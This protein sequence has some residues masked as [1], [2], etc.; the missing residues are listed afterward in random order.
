MTSQPDSS[1]PDA[2]T[3]ESSTPETSPP[4]PTDTSDPDASGPGAAPEH[5]ERSRPMRRPLSFVRRSNRLKPSYQRTWDAALGQEL[6]DIPHGERDTSVAEDFSIDWPAEFGRTA[7]IIVEIGSGSGEA[8]AQAAANHP[9]TDFLAIEVYRPGAAQL[10]SRVRREGLRNVRV[11]VAN[12]PEV[13]DQLFA[14]GQVSEVWIF[15]PDPWHKKKHNKRRLIDAG[16]LTKVARVLPE[17]GVFR[18]ATDWS[19]YAV[20]MRE[21]LSASEQFSN[22][23]AGERSGEESP[24]TEVRLYDLD[25][26]S[27]GRDPAPLPLEQARDDDGGWAPRFS[28]R[29]QTDF[30]SKALAVGRRIFDLTYIRRQDT[31]D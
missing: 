31:P 11:A 9:E 17:G 27:M 19:G 30:E 23:H 6:L 1:Q 5:F 13:L 7:P 10:A 28:G 14:P 26:K 3:P 22:P 15:F 25:A 4:D 8:V 21:V 16:F 2:S 29:A 12:A 20:Q 24:L 18:L